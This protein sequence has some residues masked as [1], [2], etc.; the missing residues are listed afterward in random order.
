MPSPPPGSGGPGT[1]GGPAGCSSTTHGRLADGLRRGVGRKWAPTPPPRATGVFIIGLPSHAG[2]RLHSDGP[3]SVIPPTG[4]SGGT[5][6]SATVT[7]HHGTRL[8]RG[9]SRYGDSH[10]ADSLTA[11]ETQLSE[12]CITDRRQRSRGSDLMPCWTEPLRIQW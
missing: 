4:Q 1:G 12:C 5:G 3:V 7:R 6:G 10:S 8:G 2:Y 11:S 9:V